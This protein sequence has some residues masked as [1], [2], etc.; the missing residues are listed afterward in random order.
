MNCYGDPA[1]K[2]GGKPQPFQREY[3]NYVLK[4]G[5]FDFA[6]A[7][8]SI[9]PTIAIVESKIAE[10]A[11]KRGERV[12]EDAERGQRVEQRRKKPNDSWSTT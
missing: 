12:S 6:E 7:M 9:M 8:T 3:A 10:D 11:N 4:S 5:T 1:Q 2:D